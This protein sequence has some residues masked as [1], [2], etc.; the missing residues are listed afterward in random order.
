MLRK[1]LSLTI[2]LFVLST[3][4]LACLNF[5]QP[6]QAAT[7]SGFTQ[8]ISTQETKQFRKL[9]TDYYAAWSIPT[10]KPWNITMAEKLYPYRG[11]GNKQRISRG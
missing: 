11:L 5:S 10:N 2:A 4:A 7:Q 6:A 8:T 1:L 3:G 9:L